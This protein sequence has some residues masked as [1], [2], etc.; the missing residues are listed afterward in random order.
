MP[1]Q[2][3]TPAV[4]RAISD[5][6]RRAILDLLREDGLPVQEIAADFAVSRPAISQHLRVL[7]DASLVRE[8]R[9]GRRRIYTLNAAPLARVDAWL[10]SYR[11]SWERNLQSLKEFV[12]AE[13]P[14][15]GTQE[16]RAGRRLGPS[17]ALRAKRRRIKSHIDRQRRGHG[18]RPD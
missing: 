17:G 16:P 12:E 14:E 6:T 13:A 15:V 8:R 2:S 4:F 9:D 3:I 18:R 5:P 1:Y 10:R 7:R 11:A